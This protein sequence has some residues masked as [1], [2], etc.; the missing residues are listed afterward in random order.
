MTFELVVVTVSVTGATVLP[1]G[2][3]G[4]TVSGAP[5]TTCNITL[6]GGTGNCSLVFT[7]VGTFTVTA[8]YNGDGNY[9][10]SWITYSHVVN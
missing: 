9:L 10:G 1:T 2:S 8:T 6:S 5:G 3:V 4:I 7:T